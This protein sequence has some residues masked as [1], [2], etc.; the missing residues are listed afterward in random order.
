VRRAAAELVRDVSS[1]AADARALRRCSARE[2]VGSVAAA[3]SA[4]PSEPA[5]GNT[6]ALVFVVP[7]GESDPVERAPFALRRPDGLVRH[8]RAD[9]RGAV[10][11]GN[12]GA[13]ELSLDVPA[14]LED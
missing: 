1:D 7:A 13:G 8:G 2:T 3:C 5:V 9:R 6:E 11:E 4:F 14:A 10:C 12:L